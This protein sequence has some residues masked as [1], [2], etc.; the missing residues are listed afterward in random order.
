[1]ASSEVAGVVAQSNWNNASGTMSV[2]PLALLNQA[3]ASSGATVTW[4]T[5][6]IW[7]LPITDSAGNNRMMR[8]YLDTVGGTTT[9]TVAGLPS[10]AGGYNVYVYADGDNGSSART[11]AYQ[12]SGT[13]ITT[14]SLKLTDVA[15]TNFSGT[16]TQANNSSGN[17]VMFTITAT[18]FTITATPGASTDSY[19][20][21][22][23]NAIQ[24]SPN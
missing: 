20:R 8:G 9:V 24:I 21:A 15:N 2:T 12:I 13:G 5:N 18:G 19:P 22:P 6:G 1:M 7:I 16:F 3:G 23:L 17:Y 10:N 11:G 4:T 14:T